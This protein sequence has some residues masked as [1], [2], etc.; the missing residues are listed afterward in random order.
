MEFYSWNL[1]ECTSTS[2]CT[3]KCTSNIKE[4]YSWNLPVSA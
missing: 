1:P 2:K 3:S 4:F